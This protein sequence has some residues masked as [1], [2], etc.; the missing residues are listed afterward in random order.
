MKEPF[1]SAVPVIDAIEEAGFEAY[2]VGGSVRD[3]LLDRSIHDVDIA[4][5][6]TPLELKRIFRKTVDVGIEHGTVIVILNGEGYEV[7]TYRTEAEYIDYRRPES[8]AFVRELEEDLRRRDFT[9]NA[10]AMDRKGKLVDPFEGKNALQEGIIRTVGSPDERF[11]EDA[12][13]LMRAVRFVSQLGFRPEKNTASALAEHA[14]LLEH[15]AVERVT[16]EMEKLLGGTYKAEAFSLLLESGLYQYLPSIF[17]EEN[18]LKDIRTIPLFFLN[19]QETWLLA[20]DMLNEENKLAALKKWRLPLRKAKSL[21][22]AAELLRQR[23]EAGWSSFLLFQGGL[24][25]VLTVENVYQAFNGHQKP[26]GEL[27]KVQQAYRNLPIKSAGELAITGHDLLQWSEKPAG[28]W[29]KDV[30]DEVIKAVLEDRTINDKS[31]I[32]RWIQACQL[33]S[34]NS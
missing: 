31:E 4:T 6:A 32:R 30:L 10:I 17:T 12:L 24:E 33:L 1:L 25:Q 16:M 18:L 26:D 14:Q 27:N 8:V 15:I 29:V 22:R 28:P 9:M 2:F 20:L 7:T 5:S 21:S 34:S 19:E 13:R 3:L 11:Q 23:K